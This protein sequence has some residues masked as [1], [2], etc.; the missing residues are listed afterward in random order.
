MVAQP[1]ASGSGCSVAQGSEE[2]RDRLPF[3]TEQTKLGLMADLGPA[4]AKLGNSFEQLYRFLNA[5]N[6]AQKWE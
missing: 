4:A 3:C 5:E 2:E 6:T 1:W